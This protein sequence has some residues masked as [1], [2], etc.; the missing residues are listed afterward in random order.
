MSDKE[1]IKQAKIEL[2]KKRLEE[3][4]KKY[5]QSTIDNLARQV[6]DDDIFEVAKA[7]S[8]SKESKEK[9]PSDTVPD[10]KRGLN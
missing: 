2:A 3:V 1:A 9:L 5:S 6:L 7:K 4:K 10:P 8:M